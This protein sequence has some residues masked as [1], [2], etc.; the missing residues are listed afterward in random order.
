[1]FSRPPG[2]AAGAVHS[3]PPPMDVSLL[4]SF[5]VVAREGQIGRAARYLAIRQSPLSRQIIRLEAQ[6]GVRLFDRSRS[7]VVLTAPG[8]M[9]LAEAPALIAL[10]HRIAERARVAAE[11]APVRGRV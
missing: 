11:P 3:G 4:H 2:S 10:T 5:L 1:M 6:L 8:R 9:L 7:G